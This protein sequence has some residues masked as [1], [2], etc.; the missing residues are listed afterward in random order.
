MAKHLD[1][2]KAGESLARSFLEQKGYRILETNWRWSR[3]EI[4]LIAKD[5]D[6]LVFVE[7]KTRSTDAFG[8]PEESIT[9]RKERFLADAASVYMEQIGHD[10]AVRFDVIS[11]IYHS[12]QHYEIEHFE[13]AFFPG[14]E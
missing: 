12:A 14:L 3:A 11:I 8:K 9:A 7:V 4:D 5:V 13:D 6:T 1:I 2:G 10:W